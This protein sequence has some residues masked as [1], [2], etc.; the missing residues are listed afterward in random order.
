MICCEK[1]NLSQSSIFNINSESSNKQ[2]NNQIENLHGSKEKNTH[3][4]TLYIGDLTENVKEIDLYNLFSKHGCISSLRI[5]HDFLTEKSL[6]YGYINFEKLK[7][8]E[9]VLEKLNF[10]SD[11][12]IFLQPLRLMW[13]NENNMLIKSGLGNLFIKNIPDFFNS[14]SLYET[15]SNFGKI[16]SCKVIFDNNGK[17][18][19][20]GF[21]QFENYRNSKKAIKK[22][23]G[24]LM[25]KREMIV[26]FF[27][28]QHKRRNIANKYINFTNI[29]VKNIGEEICNEIHIKKVFGKFGK[30]T[31][32]FIPHEKGISRGFAFVNFHDYKDAKKAIEMMNNKKVGNSVLYV[33]RAEKKKDR[34]KILK[35]IFL[36]EELGIS[37]KISQ[38][39]IIII[40]LNFYFLEIQLVRFF[41]Q[42]GKINNSKVLKNENNLSQKLAII[43]FEN[44]I[45]LSHLFLKIKPLFKGKKIIIEYLEIFK[46]LF[47]KN[48]LS[49]YILLEE[50]KDKNFY[51]FI[52]DISKFHFQ[53]NKK[54]EEK[55]NIN[56]FIKLNL[57]SIQNK[58]LMFSEILYNWVKTI[59]NK[60]SKKITGIILS[61]NL[62]K[63]IFLLLSNIKFLKIVQ[64][65]ILMP[66][67]CFFEK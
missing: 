26:D 25:Q 58:D 55:N 14:K 46:I 23:N 60:L 10:Y 15:F 67:Y 42:F 41:S 27:L 13:K 35:K 50:K 20:Y 52:N 7:D 64:K 31:S 53:T 47:K 2:T 18:M 65:I 29:Y 62:K 51:N 12:K 37:K 43:N 8:A 4:Y 66:N 38:N 6:G 24:L 16:I 57:L 9:N 54:N 28:N 63:K 56:S 59:N 32:I 39:N 5:C 22:L 30:I 40:N 17:S 1:K 49:D 48:G 36:D 61:L 3:V 21:V 33:G 44:K 45:N 19:N 34:E 11:K